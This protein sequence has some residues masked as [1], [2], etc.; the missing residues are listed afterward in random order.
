MALAS[1]K[2]AGVSEPAPSCACMER[3]VCCDDSSR[4]P[5]LP[6]H[7]APAQVLAV[8]AQHGPLAAIAKIWDPVEGLDLPATVAL[9]GQVS[10]ALYEQVSTGR[11]CNSG[12]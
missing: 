7:A 10:V 6:G 8:G 3:G 12:S 9:Y 1:L 11:V 2:S 5:C 4:Q